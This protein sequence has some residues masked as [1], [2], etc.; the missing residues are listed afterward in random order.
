VNPLAAN[1]IRT[2]V[3]II[4]GAVA[5]WLTARGIKVD[6]ATETLAIAAM[7]SVFSGA[8]YTIVRVLEEKWPAL[9]SVLLLSKPA[10]SLHVAGECPAQAEDYGEGWPPREDGPVQIGHD[11]RPAFEVAP[12]PA[13]VPVQPAV[14]HNDWMGRAVHASDVRNGI[15]PVPQGARGMY[16]DPRQTPTSLAEPSMEAGQSA[17]PTRPDVPVRP[18]KADT[19]AIP[20]YRTPPGR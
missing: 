11:P 6:P 5:S 14:P 1:L 10:A 12:D 20:V 19:G 4:V 15:A 8:Y 13:D 2:Y 3:P 17:S 16:V 18:R 7:T 9:G